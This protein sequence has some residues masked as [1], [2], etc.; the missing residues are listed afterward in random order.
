LPCGRERFGDLKNFIVFKRCAAAAGEC[1]T[2]S[3]A[4]VHVAAKGGPANRIVKY[5]FS[6]HKH[7]EFSDKKKGPSQQQ[8]HLARHLLDNTLEFQRKQVNQ[9]IGR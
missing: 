8:E 4:G 6:Y 7:T 3:F 5:C 2:S 1:A 9:C